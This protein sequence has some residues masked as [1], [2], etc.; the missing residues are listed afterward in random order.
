M[1]ATRVPLLYREPEVFPDGLTELSDVRRITLVAPAHDRAGE[2]R[3]GGA[4]AV[5]DPASGA[6]RVA[7]SFNPSGIGSGVASAALPPVEGVGQ[8]GRIPCP[9][10]SSPA[11]VGA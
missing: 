8:S 2:L 3:A 7:S 9:D 1:R 10:V 5:G 6:L 4:M 11:L